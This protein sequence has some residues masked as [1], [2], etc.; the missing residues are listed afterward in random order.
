MIKNLLRKWLLSS[1]AQEA[2]NQRQYSALT[3]MLANAGAFVV[4]FRI[5]NGYLARV[6]ENGGNTSGFIYAKD[7][8]ELS[9]ILLKHMAAVK[10]GAA[11]QGDL[12][13]QE[14]LQAQL[15][16]KSLSNH[17]RV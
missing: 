3:D 2:L 8:E 13:P 7:H 10:L 6:L 1:D 14:L 11:Q 5:K 17:F 9:T 4:I 16:A 15:S 12:F